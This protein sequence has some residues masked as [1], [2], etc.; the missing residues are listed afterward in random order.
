MH[1]TD[2][3]EFIPKQPIAAIRRTGDLDAESFT[4]LVNAARDKGRVS[5]LTHKFYRYPARFSPQF[6]RAAI[7]Q[8]SSPGDLVFDPF[9]GGGT[10]LVE[11]L[12][13]GRRA[14]GTDISSL[15]AFVSE[16][17]TL[18]LSDKEFGCLEQ[19][20]S[21]SNQQINI[22]LPSISSAGYEEAGYYRHLGSNLTWR[23]RKAM[24]QALATAV[25]LPTKRLETFAR[26]VVLRTGQ[27]A[28]DGRKQL[29]TVD[30]FREALRLNAAEMLKGAREL[31]T[32]VNN[33]AAFAPTAICLNQSIVGLD[34][35]N[36][37]AGVSPKL[38][39]TSPPYP[40]VHV[41]YHRWQVDGRKETAAPFW[42]ANKLDGSGAAYYTL[43]DRHAKDNWTY[44]EGL[45]S[46]L[47]SV[48]HICSKDTTIVQVVAFT[49]PARQLPRYLEVAEEA[50]FSELQTPFV[51]GA[52]D[53]RLWRVIP[54]RKWHAGQLGDIPASQ[55]VVL[56]HRKTTQR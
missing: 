51:S 55:E 16:A 21:T 13:L 24:E 42:I 34:Q 31:R 38:V 36:P 54:N 45:K 43:G 30:Q 5:G 44:F 49:N 56:F 2:L 47:T 46:A 53:G 26:C 29:P 11:A 40:G 7:E 10:T 32:A 23:L 19:W 3:D 18:I 22:H 14:I 48:A 33:Y 1:T 28:L 17:K 41:L 52:D 35:Q 37:C 12:A 15:A 20:V 4:Q 50:G 8:F 6:V 39:L 27:W 9:M 25:S